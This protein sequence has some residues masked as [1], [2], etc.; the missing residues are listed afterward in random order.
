[1]A[2]GGRQERTGSP[3][4]AA[5]CTRRAATKWR[6][7][8]SQLAAR[9]G[10]T[11]GY[12]R[13]PPASSSAGGITPRRAA[14]RP[15]PISAQRCPAPAAPH[16]GGSLESGRPS[17]RRAHA[18]VCQPPPRPPAG[19][20]APRGNKGAATPG[21]S[22]GARQCAHYW[23]PRSVSAGAC[24]HSRQSIVIRMDRDAEE[25]LAADSRRRARS[26]RERETP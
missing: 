26:R 20:S 19:S 12:R 23:S 21:V 14:A 6:N 2:G 11:R 1:M 15:Q 5:C 16:K 25:R 8:R 4:L 18:P 13:P 10:G 24:R 3:D 22:A 17:W 7:W 9:R